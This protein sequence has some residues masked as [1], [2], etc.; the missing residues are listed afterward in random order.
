MRLTLYYLM[1]S[2]VMSSHLI[3][4]VLVEVDIMKARFVARVESLV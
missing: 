3:S 4:P 2:H 1:S